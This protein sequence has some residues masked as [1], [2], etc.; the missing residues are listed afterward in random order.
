MTE[1]F[2]AV[3]ASARKRYES[4]AENVRMAETV[5]VFRE[6]IV[7]FS[8]T[9]LFL[10]GLLEAISGKEKKE[11]SDLM[12]YGHHRFMSFYPEKERRF[13]N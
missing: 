5:E 1:L 2:D 10:I 8:T 12:D 11:I 6:A 9:R 4:A 3:L 7:E 13:G